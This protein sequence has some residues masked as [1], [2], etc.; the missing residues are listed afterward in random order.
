MNRKELL[1]QKDRLQ[2]ELDK[3]EEM[4]KAAPKGRWR[5]GNGEMYYYHSAEGVVLDKVE[6]NTIADCN[7]FNR[8]NYFRT[9]EEAYDYDRVLRTKQK[10][11]DLAYELNNGEEIDWRNLEQRKYY[12]RLEYIGK[13]ATSLTDGSVWTLKCVGEVYCL[14]SDF[15]RRAKAEIGEQAIIDMIM[16]GV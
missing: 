12:L 2:K 1:E 14:S 9:Q 15:L 11:I 6:S 8:G 10:L 13:A 3:L 5:A 4:L 16:A 7:R